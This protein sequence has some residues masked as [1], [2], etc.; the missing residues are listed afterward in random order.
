MS[1]NSVSPAN[2]PGPWSASTASPEAAAL[3]SQPAQKKRSP[4]P[5]MTPVRRDASSRSRANA[6]YSSRL[7]ATL[8]ALA[9]GLSSVTTRVDPVTSV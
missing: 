5:V 4:A 3:R 1:K 8:T 6:A 2:P 7:V 9:F